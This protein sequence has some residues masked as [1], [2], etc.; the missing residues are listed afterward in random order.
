MSNGG[1]SGLNNAAADANQ[2]MSSSP[3]CSPAQPCGA[4]APPPTV[5]APQKKHFVAI[6]M[7]DEEGKPAAGESY[8]LTLPDGTVHEGTLD[9]K[10]RDRVD[11]I[12]PGTCKITFTDLDKDSWGPK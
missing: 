11:G 7:H 12:D 1:N 8:K 5:I 4:A 2:N 6:E 3:A 9:D 10:G